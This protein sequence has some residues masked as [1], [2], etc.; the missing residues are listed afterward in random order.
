MCKIYHDA[1]FSAE[2]MCCQVRYKDKSSESEPHK[3]RLL[4]KALSQS[5]GKHW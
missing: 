5:G 1:I 2:L 3:Q 4:P